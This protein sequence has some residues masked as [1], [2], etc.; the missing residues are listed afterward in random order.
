MI[1]AAAIALRLLQYAS[2]SVLLGA[3][4]FAVYALP[5]DGADGSSR[6]LFAGA[7]LVLAASAALGLLAQTALLAGS[8]EAVSAE[9]L[10]A[11]V[12][13]MA[14]GKAAVIRVLSGLLIVGLLAIVRPPALP[15]RRIAALAAVAVASF[16]WMGHGAGSEGGLLHLAADIVH[17]LAAATWLGA[18]ASFVALLAARP[19]P[20]AL[21]AALRRFSRIGVPLVAVLVLTGLVNSWFLVGRDGLAT[22]VTTVYGQ[23]L[24]VKLVLFAGMLVLAASN[25]YRLTPALAA[26]LVSGSEGTG[27]VTRLR[28]SIV[29]EAALG[30]GVLAAVAWFGTLPPPGS[31]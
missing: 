25:R 31:A 8:L 12:V 30:L 2:G 10:E 13:H 29:A 5:R 15:R 16:A 28:R 4:L 9:A 21:H 27:I 19:G 14:L 3:S 26:D 23:L 18:L 20:A 24:L 17:A 1:E 11:V 6:A 7:A 22:L